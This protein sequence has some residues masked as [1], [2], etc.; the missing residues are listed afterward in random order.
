MAG[1]SSAI[2]ANLAERQ[3]RTRL[4]IKGKPGTQL[5]RSK[6]VR[7]LNG[8]SLAFSLAEKHLGKVR[9]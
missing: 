9:V 6:F 5:Q 1:E 8:F 7:T 3:I 4:E 2:K